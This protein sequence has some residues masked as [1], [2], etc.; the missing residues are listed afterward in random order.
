MS[1]KALLIETLCRPHCSYYKQ[2]RNEDLLCRGAEV[3][4]LLMGRGKVIAAQGRLQQTDTTMVERITARLCSACG[5]RE[6]DCD[7]AQKP[8]ARPCGGFLLIAHLLSSGVINLDDI[9]N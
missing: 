5:F 9:D 3:I 1:K 4:E 7:F 8:R 6:Q 2:G